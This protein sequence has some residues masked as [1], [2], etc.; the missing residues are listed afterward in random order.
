[1][2]LVAPIRKVLQSAMFLAILGISSRFLGS[3]SILLG[4]FLGLPFTFAFSPMTYVT[5][6]LQ[7]LLV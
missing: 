5:K 1:M 3:F 4:S 7:G 2:R 6:L